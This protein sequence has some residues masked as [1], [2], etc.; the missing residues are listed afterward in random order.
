MKLPTAGALGPVL[1]C[2][3]FD[4]GP[5]R[6]SVDGGDSER[7]SLLVIDDDSHTVPRVERLGHFSYFRYIDRIP[8]SPL[9]EQPMRSNGAA[10]TDVERVR[11][12]TQW[13]LDS[14]KCLIC[15]GA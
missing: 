9:P 11:V 15:Q 10:R 5:V 4:V 13:H 1:A 3:A 2:L 6:A 7:R 14:R 12:R 8:S